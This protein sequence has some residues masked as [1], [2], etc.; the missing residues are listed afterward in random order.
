MRELQVPHVE[1][2]GRV[3]S[4]NDRKQ[5][6]VDGIR[7]ARGPVDPVRFLPRTD[8]DMRRLFARLAEIHQ[9][10]SCPYLRQLIKSFLGDESFRRRF[11]IAP[12]AVQNHHAYVGGLLEHVVS[13]SEACLRLTF[14]LLYTSDAADE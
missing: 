5:L 14:C 3:E 2:Q 4:Y 8:L 12:A 9:E 7:P 10:I 11:L 1:V 13:L 6:K